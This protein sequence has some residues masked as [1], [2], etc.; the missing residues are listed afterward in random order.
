[1]RIKMERDITGQ[2][3]GRLVADSP[4]GKN[5]HGNLLWRFVCE[6]GCCVVLLKSD[7]TRGATKSCGCMKREMLSI[8]NKDKSTHNLSSTVAFVAWGN[9]KYRVSNYPV[10]IQ[11]GAHK[12]WLED[13]LLFYSYIGDPPNRE[14]R[15]SLGRIDNNIGYYPGNIE[16]QRDKTQAENKAQYSNNHTGVTGVHPRTY[17]GILKG[18]AAIWR[19]GGCQKQKFFSF[20]KYGEQAFYAACK[21]RQEMIAALNA[22]GAQ[23][24]ADHGLPRSVKQQN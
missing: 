17:R 6:C 3:F 12:E 5:K 20:L 8:K 7:V 1:M 13:F 11:L 2:V 22:G 18:Y 14:P 23:Y 19:E 10:Y 4:A 16:W 24:A 15:W 21:C 9:M